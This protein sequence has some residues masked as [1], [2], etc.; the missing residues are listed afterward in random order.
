MRA[1]L[2]ILLLLT[3]ASPAAAQAP[4]AAEVPAVLDALQ[5]LHGVYPS[6]GGDDQAPAGGL[7]RLV[8]VQAPGALVTGEFYDWRAVSRYRSRPGLHLGYDL[9]L[10]AGSPVR[11]AWRGTVVAVLPWSGAECG[12][13]VES[14]NGVRTTYGHV[15]PLVSPGDLVKTGSLVGT[16]AHDHVDVKMRDATGAYLDFGRGQEA[17]AVPRDTPEAA[18]VSWLAADQRLRRATARHE[19]VSRRRRHLKAERQTLAQRVPEAERV[20]AWMESERAFGLASAEAR[21]FARQAHRDYGARLRLVET[22][23][24]HNQEEIAAAEREVRAARHEEERCRRR[25]AAHG[26]SWAHVHRLVQ[27]TVAGDPTLTRKVVQYKRTVA[28]RR[29]RR[30]ADLKGKVDRSRERLERVA[31]LYAAGV[32]ARSELAAAEEIL[33]LHRDELEGLRG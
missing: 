23:L 13:T 29:D 18:L 26:L 3:H 14:S 5:R 20:A 16:I 2:A 4:G 28:E 17:T 33:R 11:A 6:D 12:V 19:S 9:A 22:A 1:L 24:G 30:A 31:D 25:A 10:P 15:H 21:L 27:R 7:R 8:Q 32:L